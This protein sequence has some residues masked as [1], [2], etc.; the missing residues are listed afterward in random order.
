MGLI[1]DTNFV[2]SAEREARRGVLGQTD[3]FLAQRSD[4]TFFITFTVAGELACGQSASARRDWERLCRPYPILP[5][6]MEAAWQL[7]RNLP[8]P[9]RQR[10]A[11]RRKRHVD[12]R[13]RP[14]PRLRRRDEQPR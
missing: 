13:H 10:P 5:W 4:E 12:R 6:T 14:R 8:R 2:I 7:R 3:S 9:R 1:L 11:H